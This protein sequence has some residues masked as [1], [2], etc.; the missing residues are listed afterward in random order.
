MPSRWLRLLAGLWLLAM[1]ALGAEAWAVDDPELTLRQD[2]TWVGRFR[3]DPRRDTITLPV[4]GLLP[5]LS[6]NDAPRNV[7]FKVAYL[8]VPG[9]GQV[10]ARLRSGPQ[11]RFPDN[12]LVQ[13]VMLSEP[14]PGLVRLVVR[15][16]RPVRLSPRLV[17]TRQGWAI[18]VKV[19]PI[20]AV[21][22]RP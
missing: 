11:R 20:R 21:K 10:P 22:K 15:A 1:A 13:L 18:Q 7:R 8:D 3:Y 12:D 9:M 19:R 6:W 4:S 17:S 5:S 2:V 16:K 14:T